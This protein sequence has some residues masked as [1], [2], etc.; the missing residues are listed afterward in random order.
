MDYPFSLGVASGDPMPDGFVI[1]TRLAPKPLEG[2]GMPPESVE[3]S[4]IVAEDD[5]LTKVVRKGREVT[6]PDWAHSVHV[7]VNGLKPERWYWYQFKCGTET[8]PVGRS[9][10]TPAAGMVPGNFRFAFASCQHFEAGY[11]TAYE[12]M[13]RE[14]LD[15]IVHLG[16]YIYEGAGREKQ[17]RKHVGKE[18]TTIE[19]YRTRHAQYK[20]DPALQAAHAAAPWVVTWDDHELDNNYAGEISEELDVTPRQLLQRRASAYQAYYEHMPLRR[21]SIPV[22]P[23]MQLYRRVAIGHLAQF[24]VLDTRQHRTDQP[25]GDR[26]SAPCPEAMSPRATM[27]GARQRGWLLEGLASSSAHWNILAQQVMMAR[28]DRQFGKGELFSMDQWPGYEMERRKVLRLLHERKVQNP[29]ILTGDIHSNW[30]NELTLDSDKDFASPVAAEFVGTSVSS[31]G[32]GQREP[33]KLYETLSENPFV[34]FHNAERGYVTCE[35]SSKAW[36]TDFRVVECVT[37]PDA[38]ITT[39]ATFQLESGSAR[40]H[41]A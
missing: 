21:S 12:H 6:N 9:R 29:V 13:A 33:A 1:W 14:N 16:D 18:I 25:C 19:D 22:G 7:E 2:G 37:E 40:L 5:R 27:L 31:G 35:L 36:R 30:A 17:V 4:W 32:N 34:K 3:V 15:L 39:R 28:V 23:D 8:S 11:F 10:T 26:R 24:F 41:K 38:P 20:T